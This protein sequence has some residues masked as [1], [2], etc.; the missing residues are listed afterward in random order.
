MNQVISTDEVIAK[1][2]ASEHAQGGWGY[3]QSA[4][5]AEPT[6]LAILAVHAMGVQPAHGGRSLNWLVR[7]Q[8]DDG[9]WPPADEVDQS[10][11]ITALALLVPGMP[12]ES[13][14][15]GVEWLLRQFNRDSWAVERLR[16]FLLGSDP[17][18]SDGKIGWPFF[19]GTAGWVTPT[20]T[21]ILAL[22]SAAKRYP[23]DTRIKARLDGGREFLV[24]RQCPDGGW[25]YGNPEVLGRDLGSY[26][27]TTGQAL[28][29][30][31]GSKFPS[32]NK[33]LRTAEQQLA[34]AESVE[35]TAWLKLGLLAHG[36]R[37]ERESPGCRGTVDRALSLILTA[38]EKGVD[39][40]A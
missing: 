1:L 17:D 24:A 4:A 16:R 28:L 10:T 13:H 26:P 31:R 12:A 40:F 35:A 8:R 15:R 21:A 33:A 11:W 9:G 30:L 38:A 32:L 14:K 6:S 37:I 27:E 19:P 5:R 3:R 20:A 29:A 25:N 34:R 36:V 18:D 2:L 22:Q 23:N 39:S 7:R